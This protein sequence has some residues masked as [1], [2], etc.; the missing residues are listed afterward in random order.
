MCGITGQILYHPDD[1]SKGLVK[2]CGATS[3]GVSSYV[4]PVI[5]LLFMW[6]SNT[7]Y[8]VLYYVGC[9]LYYVGML[10]SVVGGTLLSRLSEAPHYHSAQRA[11]VSLHAVGHGTQVRLDVNTRSAAIVHPG[12]GTWRS[13]IA[14]YRARACRHTR[15][16]H[17]SACGNAAAR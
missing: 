1:R 16:P 13:K 8:R 11:V 6:D 10:S 9:V 4:T 5:I 14:V 15:P 2:T 3:G 12:R 17:A 7:Y